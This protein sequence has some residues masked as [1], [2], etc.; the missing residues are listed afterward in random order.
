M[1]SVLVTIAEAVKDSLNAAPDG[2]FSQSFTATRAYDP[3]WE[4]E[5]LG[6]LRVTVTPASYDS[7]AADRAR[8][9]DE[10]TVHVA[11]QKHLGDD[12]LTNTAPDALMDFVQEIADYLDRKA[13]AS[14]A[15]IR[16][17]TLA[18]YSVAHMRQQ[19][20]FTAVL[21]LTYRITR[22]PGT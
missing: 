12:W 3:L 16:T 18:P 20:V 8:N 9:Q 22:T 1:S 11:I 5:D 13:M 21:A 10:L 2:T 14:A 17:Q 4:L 19:N 15:W 6:T 7:T